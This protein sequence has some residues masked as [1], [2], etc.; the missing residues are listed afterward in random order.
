M[1]IPPPNFR[2]MCSTVIRVPLTTGLPNMMAGAISIRSW[3]FTTGTFPVGD[4]WN[5]LDYIAKL[6]V[7][8]A[9]SRG[10][11]RRCTLAATGGQGRLH[12]I[13]QLV[14]TMVE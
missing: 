8:F 1:L 11:I 4:R 2:R 14:S 9:R 6:C 7:N 5:S 12:I 3:R 13:L 10:S